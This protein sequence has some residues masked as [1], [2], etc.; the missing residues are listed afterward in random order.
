MSEGWIK[1]NRKLLKSP[2]F[3]NRDLLQLWIWLLLTVNHDEGKV[4]VGNQIVNVLP[5]QTVTGR[6]KIELETGLNRSKVERL[7]KT[8]KNEQQIEQQTFTKYRI[9]TITN[10]KL[11]QESEQQ[12]E[13]QV[14]NKRATSEH[15]QECKEG[16]ECKEKNIIPDWIPAEEWKGF[17]DMRKRIR[18]PMTDRAVQLAISTLEKLKSQG[19]DVAQ[20]LN[21]SVM[22]SYTGLF[23]VKGNNGGMGQG[24]PQPSIQASKGAAGALARAEELRRQRLQREAMEN[25]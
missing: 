3:Q 21:Q 19:E 10:W 24:L 17:I 23:P 15:K 7:L 12:N 25:V 14:S 22:K 18:K 16:K 8:L 6:N 5:G 20:V 1:L 11:Y 2:C 13:Q 4:M 9:I